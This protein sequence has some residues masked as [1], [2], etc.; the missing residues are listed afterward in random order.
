MV[1]P[2][3]PDFAPPAVVD[4]FVLVAPVPVLLF[5]AP[6]VLA[7]LRFSPLGA[8]G[9]VAVVSVVRLSVPVRFAPPVVR[10]VPPVPFVALFVPAAPVAVLFGPAAAWLFAVP[11]VLAGFA[12]GFAAFPPG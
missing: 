1:A 3:V 11:A 12:F 10:L 9:S 2:D 6:A 8:L 4:V 5:P 7:V